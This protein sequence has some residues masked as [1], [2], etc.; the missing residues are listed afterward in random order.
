MPCKEWGRRQPSFQVCDPWQ[1]PTPP[2]HPT[3]HTGSR[4]V[5]HTRAALRSG[6]Q[7]KTSL[8]ERHFCICIPE[9]HFPTPK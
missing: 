8:S 4:H 6:V 5:Q 9:A 7:V 2:T 1:A 3:H